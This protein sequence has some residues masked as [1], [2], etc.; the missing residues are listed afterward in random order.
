MLTVYK[1]PFRIEDRFVLHL[2]P[3]FQILKVECQAGVPCM[4]VLVNSG[5][6]AESVPFRIYG[7]GHDIKIGEI[8]DHVATFQQG[9]FVWHLFRSRA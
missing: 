2:P 3:G 8:G 5:C 7:T 9:E 1:Y 6:P 4:W